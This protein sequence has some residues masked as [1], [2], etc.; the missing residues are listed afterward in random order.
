MALSYIEVKYNQQETKSDPKVAF[1]LVGQ[2][3]E[4]NRFPCTS[5]FCCGWLIR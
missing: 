3:S 5:T 2:L 1:L 4:I